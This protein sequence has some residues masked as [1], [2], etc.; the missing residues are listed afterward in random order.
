MP[1]RGSPPR[2]LPPRP[3]ALP[4]RMDTRSKHRRRVRPSV[5]RRNRDPPRPSRRS[6]RGDPLTPPESPRTE[7]RT[8]PRRAPP[9]A[10]E[11][12][13]DH[14]CDELAPSLHPPRAD[15]T[16]LPSPTRARQLAPPPR[17]VPDLRAISTRRTVP[18]TSKRSPPHPAAAAAGS[19]LRLGPS[20]TRAAAAH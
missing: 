9:A 11:A 16:T 2:S 3:S 1:H 19:C 5:D 17:P 15:T 18:D 12:A 14:C 20:I 8:L 7:P 6:R 10:A 13:Q 4:L